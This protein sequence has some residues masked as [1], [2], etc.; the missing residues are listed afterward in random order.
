MVPPKNG[1]APKQVMVLLHGYGSDGADLIGLA[2][3]WRELLPEA[4]FVAPNAP[5]RCDVNPGGYQW[6]ALDNA[7][8]A[9]RADGASRAQPVIAEFLA[10]FWRQ[11]G[12]GAAETFLCGFSQGAMMALHVALTLP[13]P[14]RGVVGFSGALIAPAGFASYAGP[15][16]PVCLVHGDRDPVVDVEMSVMAAA[17]LREKG[18]DV[19]LHIAPGAGHTISP[20]GLDF[21]SRFVAAVAATV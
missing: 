1:G 3:R 10:D 14:V 19:A 13:E 6:F 11:T 9:F 21:A 8:P 7:D 5:E 4:V 16:P 20:D 12:L 2:G 17:T 15:R 18:F